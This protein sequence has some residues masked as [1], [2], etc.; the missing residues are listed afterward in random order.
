MARV[1]VICGRGPSDAPWPWEW[2]DPLGHVCGGQDCRDEA[3]LELDD[4]Y[5]GDVA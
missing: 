1:C 2:V 4:W 5:G 3:E